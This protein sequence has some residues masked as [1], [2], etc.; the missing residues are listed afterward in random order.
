MLDFSR[1]FAV[2]REEVLAAIE[3]VCVSQRFIL[4][5]EVTR[6]EQAAAL[7]C[8]ASYGIGCASGT[9]ALWLAMEAAHIGAS[10]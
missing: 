2:I 5:P 8:G 4:G 3:Q 6:F 7:A 10:R 9:D 1:Q